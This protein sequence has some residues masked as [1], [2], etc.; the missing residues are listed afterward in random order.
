MRPL[1]TSSQGWE[2]GQTAHCP[3]NAPRHRHDG[4]GVW[5][6]VFGLV[7]RLLSWSVAAAKN[8][9]LSSGTSP[10][11]E[12]G[13]GPVIVT[14][15]DGRQLERESLWGR[16]SEEEVDPKS[17][18]LAWLRIGEDEAREFGAV[19]ERPESVDNIDDALGLLEI[20]AARWEDLQAGR[21]SVPRTIANL[22][23]RV[24]W[25]IRDSTTLCQFPGT[26]GQVRQPEITSVGRVPK[27]K[28]CSGNCRGLVWLFQAE[29]REAFGQQLSLLRNTAGSPGFGDQTG[30]YSMVSAFPS[31]TPAER[32]CLRSL[33][34]ILDMRSK[35]PEP[36]SAFS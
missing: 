18:S 35:H 13:E 36:R 21:C 10:P 30:G 25:K 3:L 23:I 32:I 11:A 2:A 22:P 31:A 15:N 28:G 14:K 27:H 8:S 1:R 26:R 33:L 16:M 6:A 20:P 17:I 12:C 4:P 34:P 29:N 7:V 24:G 9:R 19:L 5:I